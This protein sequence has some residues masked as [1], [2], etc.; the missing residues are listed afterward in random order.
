MEPSAAKWRRQWR[1]A[2]ASVACRVMESVLRESPDQAAEP[3]RNRWASSTSLLQEK[4]ARRWWSETFLAIASAS[5]S[6]QPSRHWRWFAGPCYNNGAGR[7]AN[8]LRH[9]SLSVGERTDH[10]Y[11]R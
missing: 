4:K 1:K 11:H 3:S 9:R 8:I 2:F 7:D 10:P 6:S 5:A